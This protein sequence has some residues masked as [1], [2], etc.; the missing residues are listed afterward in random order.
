MPKS[1]E[2]IIKE[3][4]EIME[5][6]EV[7]VYSAKASITIEADITAV[8]SSYNDPDDMEKA[9]AA[10][11]GSICELLSDGHFTDLLDLIKRGSIKNMRVKN[12][13]VVFKQNLS[14]E[15]NNDKR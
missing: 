7:P 13:N 3:V 1:K 12:P 11:L 4:K 5:E 8:G 9:F 2:E 14:K 10:S 6:P 15:E